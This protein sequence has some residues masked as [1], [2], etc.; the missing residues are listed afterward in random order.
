MRPEPK[1]ILFSDGKKALL[2]LSSQKRFKG[3]GKQYISSPAGT[4]G[5]WICVDQL[6]VKHA[7]LLVDFLSNKLGNL[8]WRM[9]PYDQLALK[10]GLI[11]SQDDETHTIKLQVEFEAIYKKWSRGHKS[12]TKKAKKAGFLVKT[13]STLDDWSHYYQ[14]YEDSLRRWGDKASSKYEWELFNDIFQRHSANTKL[15]L[16]IYQEQVVSGILCF[17]AKKHV[18]YW[19][20]ATLEDFFHLRP[21]NLLMYESIKDACEQKY[22]CFDFN[23]SGGHEGVKEFKQRFGSEALSCPI[24]TAEDSITRVLAA[25]KSKLR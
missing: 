7:N 16:A 12:A 21:V 3:L 15:W 17:Y 9:N 4:F 25:V 20:G 10:L 5:G 2:P 13:A 11:N 8:Y 23:P 18:V 24:V 6:D 1:L 22:D 14:V 19:H